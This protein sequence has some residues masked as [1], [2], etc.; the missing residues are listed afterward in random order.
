MVDVKK[1]GHLYT[2]VCCT[3]GRKH[4]GLAIPVLQAYTYI[5][6]HVRLCYRLNQQEI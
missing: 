4:N 6:W 5:L 2:M 1:H 3:S